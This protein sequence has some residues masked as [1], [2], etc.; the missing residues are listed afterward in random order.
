MVADHYDLATMEEIV[1]LFPLNQST[2]LLPKSPRLA[3]PA[4][5][6]G[7]PKPEPNAIKSE[8]F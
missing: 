2:L 5:I 4:T 7:T 6:C 8:K 1:P 3:M